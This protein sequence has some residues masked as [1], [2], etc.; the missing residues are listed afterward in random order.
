[1]D[2]HTCTYAICKSLYYS[3]WAFSFAMLLK[4]RGWVELIT[5]Q[6]S[7]LSGHVTSANM[8]TNGAVEEVHEIPE[9]GTDDDSEE[10]TQNENGVIEVT[11]Q[12]TAA[13]PP[14]EP[15]TGTPQ[16]PNLALTALQRL[17]EANKKQDESPDDFRPLKR[18]RMYVKT[19]GEGEVDENE[20]VD[21]VN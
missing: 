13:P 17:R 5:N 7:W 15:P 3:N 10:E 14:A 2:A 6:I 9:S 16:L 18:R 4:R 21:E 1:M 8:A 20:E 11:E 19:G 12:A